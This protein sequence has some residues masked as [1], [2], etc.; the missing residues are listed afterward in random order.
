MNLCRQCFREKSTD[1]GFN[2]VSLA[3]V[4]VCLKEGK[5]LILGTSSGNWI[6]RTERMNEWQDG[7]WFELDG[8][9]VDI[10]ADGSVD[11][12]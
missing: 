1:I 12:T 3:V 11:K 4:V 2:K 9:E 5:V 6:D 8:V 10:R 7:G